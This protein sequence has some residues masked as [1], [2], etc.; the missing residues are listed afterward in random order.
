[1]IINLKINNFNSKNYK[2]IINFNYLFLKIQNYYI[3]VLSDFC[4]W[5]FKLYLQTFHQY[6]IQFLQKLQ[7]ISYSCVYSKII[8]FFH[9]KF[10]LNFP[11]QVYYQ[12]RIYVQFH[13]AWNLFPQFIFLYFLSYSNM[14]NQ[15]QLKSLQCFYNIH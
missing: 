4:L 7:N 12:L 8:Q 2:T 6:F 14:I 1:M 5:Q 13:K 10:I 9:Q 3:L 15:T 11:N